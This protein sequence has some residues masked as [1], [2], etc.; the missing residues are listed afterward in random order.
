MNLIENVHARLWYLKKLGFSYASK[1]IIYSVK[2]KVF[3]KTFNRH[4][5]DVIQ[6]KSTKAKN[7]TAQQKFFIIESEKT[8]RNERRK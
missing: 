6:P 5:I 3:T 4:Q 1:R 2:K 7:Q 8:Y